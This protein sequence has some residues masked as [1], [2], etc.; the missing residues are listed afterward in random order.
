VFTGN[1]A[2]TAI[3]SATKKYLSLFIVSVDW[4]FLITASKIDKKNEKSKKS[5]KMRELT[6][7]CHSLSSRP[8]QAR[9]V[10]RCA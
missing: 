6:A 4:M 3:A 1:R 8:T 5:G 10:T 7:L 9:V 2:A